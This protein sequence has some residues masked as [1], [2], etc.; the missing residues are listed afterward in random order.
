MPI[1]NE[2]Y[3][4]G[5]KTTRFEFVNAATGQSWGV[6]TTDRRYQVLIGEVYLLVDQNQT[7]GQK[8]NKRIMPTHITLDNPNVDNSRVTVQY[9]DSDINLARMEPYDV[10][11][12]D[13]DEVL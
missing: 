12:L 13:V 9:D 2:D 11:Y 3:L 4:L 8:P 1:F 6:F 7:H 10:L 5:R